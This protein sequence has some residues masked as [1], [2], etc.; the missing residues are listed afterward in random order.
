[1]R[2]I[3]SAD[4]APTADQLMLRRTNLGR[5]LRQLRDHGPRS[6]ATLATEL[7][8]TRTAVS[9]LVTDLA[10]RGLVRTGG[11]ERGAVGRPGTTVELDGHGVC[12]LG[13]EVNVNHVST[14]ALDL[15][16]RVV[17]EHKLGLDA[18]AIPAEEVIDRLAELVQQTLADLARREIAPAGLTVG[19]AG[20]VDRERDVLTHGPNLGWHDVPVGDLLRDR[21]G[22]TYPI[23]VDNEGNLAAIAEATPGDPGRQDILVIFGEVGVGGGIVADGRLLR[24]RQGYAGEFGHMIVEPQGR[25]CGCGRVGCWETVSGLRAVLDLAADPDDPVRDPAL[26]I[27]DRLAELNRR[28]A[29]GDTRTLAALEQVGGWVGVGTAMLANALNPA[30]IVLS[31]Y[32]AAVGEHMRPA[33]EDRL[34]AGVLAPDAGGTRVELSTLGFTAAVRG[35]AQLALETVFADPTRVGRRTTA[36]G[37]T[38]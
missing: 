3:D 26:G 20:L 35:G 33:I 37:A 18:H 22:T 11:V 24:G 31:G 9:N 29:L 32:F 25:R 5:V 27:D 8:L 34:R 21:L 28:A 13:A 17:S 10:D 38:R 4:Q 23:A 6:R 7:G 36:E 19:V 14:L 30:A 16:G 15:G 12:G 2:R 1:V